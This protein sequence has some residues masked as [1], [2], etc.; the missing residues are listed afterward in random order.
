MDYEGGRPLRQL[1][2]SEPLSSGYNVNRVTLK[3]Y[4]LFLIACND[5]HC[6]VAGL[7]GSLE[8]AVNTNTILSIV[9][10][11]KTLTLPLAK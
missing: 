11:K 7:C 3:V 6:Q 10:Q 4:H 8:N 5:D 9:F 2:A 1:I